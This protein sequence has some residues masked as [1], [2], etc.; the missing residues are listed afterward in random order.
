MGTS[1]KILG[2]LNLRSHPGGVAILLVDFM[3]QKPWISSGN[4]GQFWPECGFLSCSFT[5]AFLSFLTML[6]ELD[7]IAK[8]RVTSPPLAN[9][10]VISQNR[11]SSFRSMFF[12]T[13]ILPWRNPTR[14]SRTWWKHKIIYWQV[15]DH[16]SNAWWYPSPLRT[17]PLTPLQSQNLQE[18]LRHPKCRL[19]AGSLCLSTYSNH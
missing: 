10:V 18:H 6:F 8:N 2:V 13:E 16:S 17:P 7:R 5:T 3:L 15:G 4:V 14:N 19:Q 1:D 12:K 9:C 11:F